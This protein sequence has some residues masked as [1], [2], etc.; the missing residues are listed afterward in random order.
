MYAVRVSDARLV[1]RLLCLQDDP[2]RPNEH[3]HVFA[4][5]CIHIHYARDGVPLTRL[6]SM[7][8]GCTER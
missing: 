5:R 1:D 6:W 4:D 7:V 2:R 3:V 8:P